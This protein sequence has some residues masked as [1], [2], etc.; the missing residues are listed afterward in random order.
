MYMHVC[1]AG[2]RIRTFLRDVLSSSRPNE[3]QVPTGCSAVTQELS[4]VTGQFLRLA[5]H[6]RSVFGN[7]YAAIIKET[8]Q[9]RESGSEASTSE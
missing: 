8:L 2:S 1:A 3:S 4:H 6:N 5:S 7:Y 9:K